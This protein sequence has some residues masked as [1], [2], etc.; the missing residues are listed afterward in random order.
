MHCAFIGC[1]GQCCKLNRLILNELAIF[2][3]LAYS[4]NSKNLTVQNLLSSLQL[5]SL[6]SYYNGN[7][8]F[9]TYLG[10]IVKLPSNKG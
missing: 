1:T 10:V 6:S 2:L 4:L 7:L 3:S 5:L 8:S 9:V